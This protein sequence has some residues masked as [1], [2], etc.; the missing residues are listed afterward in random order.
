MILL[1][2]LSTRAMF[3]KPIVAPTIEQNLTLVEPIIASQ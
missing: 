1:N 2:N 3:A